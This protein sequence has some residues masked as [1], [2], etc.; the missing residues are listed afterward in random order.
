ME[1]SKNFSLC[2][3]SHRMD[4][5]QPS[6]SEEETCYRTTRTKK[7]PHEGVTRQSEEHRDTSSQESRGIACLLG[8]S[9]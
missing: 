6:F 9:H 4:W 3:S 5:K 1:F 7:M 2:G 8:L